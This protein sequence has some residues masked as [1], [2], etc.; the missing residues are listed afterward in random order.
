MQAALFFICLPP[1]L[2]RAACRL[3]N[4]ASGGARVTV[5]PSTKLLKL[6]YLAAALLTVA[7]AVFIGQ[8]EYPQYWMLLLPAIVVVATAVKHAGRRFTRLAV[9][10]NKLRYETGMLAR[11]CR[12]MELI[13]VQDVRVEQSIT[14]R[15]LNVGRLTI[16]TAG[17]A[18][19]L[20][21]EN[22]DRPNAVADH[23]LDAAHG[24]ARTHGV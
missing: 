12:T 19:R 6:W 8:E 5:Y 4:I 21:V 20:T 22:I 7:I 24:H 23:I 14:Q 2:R 15:L 13:K 16:E 17:E 1:L 18:G 10:G 9:D 11:S 3:Y